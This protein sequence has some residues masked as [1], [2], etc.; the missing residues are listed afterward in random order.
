MKNSKANASRRKFMDRCVSCHNLGLPYGSSVGTFT[1]GSIKQGT[2]A[3][4]TEYQAA[5]GL[6]Q[7]KRLE[8]QTVTRNDKAAYLKSKIEM[9][10][11]ICSE[12]V[13][14]IQNL[15]LVNKDDMGAIAYAI[16]KI[17]KNAG[18]IKTA[19]KK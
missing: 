10:P 1:T 12:A 7:L 16:E 2:K 19:L 5:I 11:G 15:L 6:A 9:I 17:R 3:R 18:A 8:A 4:F 14:F 13:W